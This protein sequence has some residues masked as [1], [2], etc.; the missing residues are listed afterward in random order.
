MQNEIKI[1]RPEYLTLI[2]E[3]IETDIPKTVPNLTKEWNE[4]YPLSRLSEVTMRKYLNYIVKSDKQFE[5]Q[6]I[7]GRH[8]YV[9][10]R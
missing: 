3:I 7:S 8:G 4:K 5:R 2:K 6:D 9:R 10:K 1:A